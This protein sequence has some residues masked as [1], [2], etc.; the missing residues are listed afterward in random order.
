MI[1]YAIASFA[2]GAYL[3]PHHPEAAR[4]SAAAGLVAVVFHLLGAWLDARDGDDVED[5]AL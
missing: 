4:I 5:L 3:A 1:S 2:F